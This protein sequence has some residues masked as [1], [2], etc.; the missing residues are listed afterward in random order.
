ML[1][2]K[3]AGLVAF[4]AAFVYGDLLHFCNPL[5]FKNPHP[6]WTYCEL[7]PC[8]TPCSHEVPVTMHVFCM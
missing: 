5:S 2:V 4:L 1:T 3:D 7:L 8:T 6:S